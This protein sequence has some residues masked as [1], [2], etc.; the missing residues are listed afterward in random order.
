MRR[1]LAPSLLGLIAVASF[2]LLLIPS[3]VS[4]ASS[5]VN[6]EMPRAGTPILS[7]R[8]VP[9]LLVRTVAHIRLETDLDAALDDPGLGPATD[10][11]CLTVEEG[12]S[13]IYERR[14]DQ[15]LIP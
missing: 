3:A 1:W 6:G 15:R 11:R 4:D 14:P 10:S 12:D 2:G 13:S 8:R 9:E 7:P 5:D